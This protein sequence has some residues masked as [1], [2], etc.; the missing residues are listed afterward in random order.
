M[1]S[2][3]TLPTELI[4][5]ISQQLPAASKISLAQTNRQLRSALGVPKKRNIITTSAMLSES[6]FRFCKHCAKYRPSY[7][8]LAVYP[9]APRRSIGVCI[10]CHAGLA[11]GTPENRGV[12]LWKRRIGQYRHCRELVVGVR[13][14]LLP[15]HG[16]GREC[17]N[18]SE[19]GLFIPATRLFCACKPRRA[20][21]LRWELPL[22]K[23]RHLAFRVR[24]LLA[25]LD[26]KL[27]MSSMVVLCDY[28]HEFDPLNP[29]YHLLNADY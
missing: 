27:H 29:D 9:R 28:I 16:W 4:S 24:H 14:G 11:T 21:D 10:T 17:S 5:T 20:L 19:C 1:P 7:H 2:L 8:F 12:W 15:K 26:R 25:K 6:G 18:C 23:K 13:D 3:N 22:K